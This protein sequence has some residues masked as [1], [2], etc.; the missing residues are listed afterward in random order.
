MNTL[1]FMDTQ[2]HGA[3]G[4]GVPTSGART[5]FVSAHYFFLNERRVVSWV[6]PPPPTGNECVSLRGLARAIFHT[7]LYQFSREPL[8]CSVRCTAYRLWRI[9]PNTERRSSKRRTTSCICLQQTFKTLS[10]RCLKIQMIFSSFPYQ[11]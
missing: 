2:K 8:S 6:Q 10:K 9:S 1:L 3:R 7:H 5:A 4:Y 11:S